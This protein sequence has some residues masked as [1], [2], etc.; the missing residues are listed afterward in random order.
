MLH[1]LERYP[2][3]TLDTPACFADPGLRSPEE[4]CVLIVKEACRTA[5]SILYLPR[6][7]SW[8]RTASDSVH[9][10]VIALLEEIPASR[11]PFILAFAA[12]PLSDFPDE[13]LTIFQG[14]FALCN[15]P[16]PSL[17]QRRD[18]FVGLK[19]DIK[20]PPPPPVALRLL[21][22]RNNLSKAGPVAPAKMTPSQ[23]ANLQLAEEAT[24]RQLRMYLRECL[25]TLGETKKFKCFRHAIDPT[26]VPDYST[27][28]QKPMHLDAMHDTNDRGDYPTPDIFLA[29]INL[30]TANALEYNPPT[31]GES[32]RV[33]T[34]AIDF[35]D[36]AHNLIENASRDHP[37]LIKECFVIQESRLARNDIA[38]AAAALQP[39]RSLNDVPQEASRSL[40]HAERE[41]KRARLS[42]GVYDNDNVGVDGSDVP[43]D[44][45]VQSDAEKEVIEVK[46]TLDEV[47]LDQFF[48]QLLKV[49]EAY[50]VKDMESMRAAI[51]RAALRCRTVLDRSALMTV[52]FS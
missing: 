42:D 24:L 22:K 5:P 18:F 20:A 52:I 30:I 29:D 44:M 51:L 21:P 7:D 45:L 35:K 49:S 17:E 41:A 11:A 4:A 19:E 37:E 43:V 9:A 50:T 46:V 1:D 31:D 38:I 16:L 23:L 13:L 28:I 12:G 2:I 15:I 8:W 10:T 3:F 33:R 26:D 47:E 6:V 39:I 40:R 34:A 32:R 25:K 27:F 14:R 36:H 48:S